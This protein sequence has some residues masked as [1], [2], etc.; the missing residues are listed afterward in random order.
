MNVLRQ[1]DYRTFLAF[2]RDMPDSMFERPVD[3]ANV[4]V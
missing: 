1:K 2:K 3:V 4:C